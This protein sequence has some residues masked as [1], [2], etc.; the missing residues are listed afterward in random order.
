[1]VN[2]IWRVENGQKIDIWEDAWILYCASRKVVTP[3]GGHLLSRVVDFID[4]T[5]NNWNVNLVRQPLWPISAQQ[6]LATPFPLHEMQDFVAW[7]FTKNSL[8]LIRTT[9][10]VEWDHQHGTKLRCTNGM[11]QTTVNPI[12]YLEALVPCKG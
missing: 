9:F 3:R 2:Y 11:G 12:W 1:M 7:S 10:L 6:V 8:F 5:F 4:P